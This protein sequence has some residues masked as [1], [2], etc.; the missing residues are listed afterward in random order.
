MVRGSTPVEAWMRTLDEVDFLFSYISC[1]TYI[2]SMKRGA[3]E[4][5]FC[6]CCCKGQKLRR[7]LRS[8]SSQLFPPLRVDYRNLLNQI[9]Q[10]LN[11]KS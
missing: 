6:C 8:L 2:F 3:S 5:S 9:N 11:K 7:P 10:M 1:E 4:G